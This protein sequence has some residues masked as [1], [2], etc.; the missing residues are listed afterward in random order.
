MLVDAGSGLTNAVA[1]LRNTGARASNDG[2]GKLGCASASVSVAVVVF[3]L[4]LTIGFHR[5]SGNGKGA[6]SSFVFAIL[7]TYSKSGKSALS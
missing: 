7:H 6:V 1:G 3:Q 2:A 4:R 5:V